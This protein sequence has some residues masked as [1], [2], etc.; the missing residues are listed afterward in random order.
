M[1]WQDI[2]LSAGSVMFIIALVPSILSR[3]KPAMA[4]SLMTSLVLIGFTV[5][6]ASLELWFTTIIT[7]ITVAL[8]LTL[9]VQ[10]LLA[11]RRSA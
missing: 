3:D 11:K 5:T 1:S 10:K 8:W 6:Y 9:F 4:T 2:V 7:I